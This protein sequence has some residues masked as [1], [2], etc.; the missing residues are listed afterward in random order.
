[1]PDLTAR[2]TDVQT[3]RQTAPVIGILGGCGGAGASSLAAVVAARGGGADIWPVLID[4]DPLGGGIDVALGAEHA[5]GARWSGLYA[6]GG[7]LDPDQLAEGLPRWADVPFL[8]CDTAMAPS[9]DAVRSVLAAAAAIGPVIVDLGRSPT[10][11]RG[12]ALAVADAVVLL[13]PADVRA[14]SAAACVRDSAVEFG[15]QWQ[16]VVR[17]SRR[18]VVGPDW[19]AQLLGL[20]LTGVLGADGGLRAG[21]D[22]GIEAH[23]VGRSTAR[24]A[25][26]LLEHVSAGLPGETRLE[27]DGA[28]S[29]VSAVSA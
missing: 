11:A 23:R 7:R 13:V 19:A 4:L 26:V 9:P 12:A 20:P 18:T 10:P 21:R 17:S 8:A 6:A 25:R 24:L 16:L 28:V 3:H 5:N 15:G 27:L 2:L 29:A 14:I 22:R 1:M